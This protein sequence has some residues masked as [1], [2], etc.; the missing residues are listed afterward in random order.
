MQGQADILP[1]HA[2]DAGGKRNGL[3]R[4][5]ADLLISE[6]GR[7]KCPLGSKQIFAV[8]YVVS[9]LHPK[10]DMCGALADVRF[11][12]IADIDATAKVS[13]YDDCAHRP[14]IQRRGDQSCIA[15]SHAG[16]SHRRLLDHLIQLP[17]NALTLTTFLRR[18]LRL[19]IEEIQVFRPV[20]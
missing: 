9:A 1:H 17:S 14:A 10:A 13:F 16:R 2:R 5:V 8:R 7:T 18:S 6:W 3:K 11:V 20:V 15:I 12:P 4:K 19:P